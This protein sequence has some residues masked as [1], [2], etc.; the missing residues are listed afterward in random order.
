MVSV[1]YTCTMKIKACCESV[2]KVDMSLQKPINYGL[3]M[4]LEVSLHGTVS[5]ERVPEL[6][7]CALMWPPLCGSLVMQGIV[8]GR[9]GV[10]DWGEFLED[11]TAVDESDSDSDSSVGTTEE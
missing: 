11:A 1:P 5:V 9:M 6:S 8:E 3:S 10:R 4:K 7:T 2:C